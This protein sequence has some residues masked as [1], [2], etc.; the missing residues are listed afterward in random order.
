MKLL[1]CKSLVS[2][3]TAAVLAISL[4]PPISHAQTS[5]TGT[6]TGTVT[7]TSGGAVPNVSVL[8]TDTDTGVA[9][10]ISTNGAGE[11]TA[12]FL[13]PGNYEVVIGGANYNKFDRKNL[14]LTVGQ[15][16]SID[17]SLSAGAVSTEVQVTSETP[18]L[19][20]EKTEVSQTVGQQLISNLP[21]NARNWSNF[22]LLTPNV[23]PDG[24]SGLV[25]FRG[26]SGLYNQNYVD[27]ANNNQMLF[28]EA[29][30]RSSGAPYV[31]SLDSIKEF[32]AETSN[33]SVEFGQAVGGQVNAITKSGTN[34]IHGDLFY[35]LRYPTLNA[36][37]PLT[38][39]NAKF[40]TANPTAAAFLQ[41]QPIHQ[42]QQ[43]GGSVG[44][45]IVKDR[46][47]YFFTYDGFRRVG[48]ALYYNNNIIT[49]TPTTGN[50]AGT[51]ISPTQCPATISSTQCTSAI[52]F[53]LGN[54][55][56]A[57]T[58]FAK[59]NLFFPR[60]DWHISAANDAFVNY[61]F[62]NFDSTFGYNSS[63][64]FSGSSPS[65]NG[66]TS[67][68]ER[69][70]IAGLTTLVSSRSVNQVHFQYGRDL[71][72][73]GSNGPAPSVGMGVFTYGLPNALPRVAEPDEHRT[74][75]TDVFSTVHGHHA[76]KFG[77]DVNLVHEVMINL[78]QGGG[79][80]SYSGSN[81]QQNFQSWVQDIFRGQP[82]DTDPY[83]G[84]HY[85]SFVQTVDQVNTGNKAGKDDF[86]MKMFDG[87]AEDSW[88]LRP[89]FTVTAGIRYD[90]QITPA[91]IKK[92]TNF[93]PL[94]TFY[95]STI[96]NTNRV[97]PRIAAS[98]QPYQGTVVRA[99]YGLF[100]GLNQGSTY[101]AMRVENGVV[102]VNYNYTGCGPASGAST[103]SCKT[104]PST[105]DTLQFPNVPF[106][107][108]GPPLS[109]ALTPAGGTAPAIG[110]P[111]KLGPQSFHGLDPNFVPP[112]AH[113]AELGVE[114]ALPGNLSL[115]VGYVGTRALRLPVFVDAN[116]RGQAPHGSR[117]YNVVDAG[118]NLIKQLSVPVYLLSDRRDGRIQSYN[119]GFSAANT[120]YNSLAVSVRRP[121][122]NGLELL[123]NYTWS[124][125]TD[126]DQVQGA[127]GTFYGGNA[128][129][130]PN[131]LK[132]ENGLSDIDVRSR[133]VGSFVYSPHLFEQNK[134]GKR[135]V[136]GF[137]FA[138]TETASA[139]Q[140]IVA[141]MSGTVY[142]GGPTSYGADG[143][144][145]GGAMSSGSGVATTGRP[146]QIGRNS[147]IGPGFNN[148]DFRISREIP[149]HESIRLQFSGESFN[150][151]NRRI[152]TGVNTTYSVY[153]S[154]TAPTTA[155]PKPACNAA[156]Q[157]AGTTASPLQGCI[158]PFTGTANN[159]FGAP[160][161]TN[162][163][164]YGPRQLQVSA[165][166]F[167]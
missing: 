153:N 47:F 106:A 8:I 11:Y 163:T 159:A 41:T 62:A 16:L 109:A 21:V 156:T 10:T 126:T 150:L 123:F 52:D 108:T 165:K 82:G 12:P 147:I 103:S 18:L 27:G 49:Q 63:P 22:V 132:L 135:L 98:W 75:I 17:A 127:F 20:T 54:S 134:W 33:Y 64:T 84:Y 94:S 14:V 60:V 87:F 138:G 6:I 149:I 116:L 143:N 152:I 113:E 77:G 35:S 39:W 56:A 15:I 73:A 66:A 45:P 28:S 72:T 44:G 104:V 61:N 78:F 74:Q 30:G 46:L 105:T 71:E 107:P 37:D 92:N 119:T 137:T 70:L 67:Y 167:F 101:Y 148:F 86:W 90:I 140:P 164:L 19:D 43:F 129:L 95:S 1:S 48:K 59:T 4:A 99:G 57:P 91:P 93:A 141:S 23:V 151:L 146:P 76:L 124:R 161:T 2:L 40:N 42:Q 53:I 9:R 13:Q 32:Q 157:A 120:W 89:N 133:F 51:I 155:S 139:G 145:Y 80:Y 142:N 79:I 26:I 88:K 29:R 83:A 136:D 154:A 160:S 50:S 65:T 125:A 100:S 128:V 130:D 97:Q 3:A 7:D 25:A 58:R 121:F 96:K 55:F 118:G 81:S 115:S 36:L 31:Y 158:A 34:S 102:Q 166:L 69:F 112:L 144:I 85:T 117:T 24:G 5:G 111:A 114:Q 162:N 110:G 131:N 68:H 38:K 122:S